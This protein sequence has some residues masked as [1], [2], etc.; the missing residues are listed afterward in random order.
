MEKRFAIIVPVKDRQ[1]YLNV[2]LQAVPR[3]LEDKNGLH[4]YKIFVAEQCDDAPFNLSLARNVGACFA[5]EENTYAYLVFHDVDIIPIANVDYG[6]RER[7]VCWFMKA[8]TC[9][10]QTPAFRDA[11]GYNPSIWGWCNEDYE[12]YSRVRDFGHHMDTWHL[13]PESNRAVIV[14]LDLRPGPLEAC[15]EFSKWYFK[16]DALGPLLISYNLTD[17]IRPA[18]QVQRVGRR[19]KNWHFERLSVRHR[20][21]IEFLTRMPLTVKRTYADFYGLNWVNRDRVTVAVN[22]ERLCHL[23]YSWFDVVD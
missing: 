23:K 22:T 20:R 6:Y 21:I 17:H 3:Y 16:Y 14:D 10:I 11:N 7:N 19:M 15:R 13:L 9:K 1:A 8:G 12:F 4:N 2:F 18:E 5:L